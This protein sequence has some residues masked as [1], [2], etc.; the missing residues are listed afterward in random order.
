[1]LKV[2][3][4]PTKQSDSVCWKPYVPIL[5]TSFMFYLPIQQSAAK[6][7]QSYWIRTIAPTASGG[8]AWIGR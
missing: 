4:E 1:M 2:N 3:A 7:I 8:L 6:P 5:S